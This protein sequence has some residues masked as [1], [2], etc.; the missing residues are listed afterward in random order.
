MHEG[1]RARLKQSFLTGGLEPFSPHNV[2]ELILFYAL[3]R[4]DT[5]KIAH[6]LLDRFG[7]LSA[8]FDA[9]VEELVKVDG[10]GENCAVL[11]KLFPAVSRTYLMDKQSITEFDDVESVGNY[12]VSLFIGE[13][14]EKAYLLCFDSRNRLLNR[15]MLSEGSLSTVNLDKRR[16]IE[17]VIRNNTSSVILTHNHPN[18]VAAPSR[19]DVESTRSISHLLREISI[20]FLDHIIVADNDYFS[21]MNHLNFVDLFI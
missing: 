15:I 4:K 18:G 2:L 9:P 12:C 11:I 3:P 19:A 5:N 16:L 17:A 21:M 20:K 10:I 14:T 1:H 6:A 7:S 13:V 8:V